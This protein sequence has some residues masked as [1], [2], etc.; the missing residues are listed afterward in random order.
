MPEKT[1]AH[2]EV[3]KVHRAFVRSERFQSEWFQ[4]LEKYYSLYRAETKRSYYNVV[5]RSQYVVPVIFKT[6]ETILPRLL[7]VTFSVSPPI[8]SRWR[9]APPEM[10]A[11]LK[12]RNLDYL[13]EFQKDN[14]N[15]FDIIEAWFKENLIYG[16]AYLKVGWKQR[17][18]K[19]KV[20]VLENGVLREKEIDDVVE[21]RAEVQ[22][23]DIFNLFFSP[24][25]KFPDPFDTAKYVIFRTRKRKSEV[26]AMRDAGQYND[27]DEDELMGDLENDPQRRKAA[28]ISRAASA[29]DDPED[30]MVTIYEYWEDD[31]LT[32]TANHRVLLRDEPNPFGMPGRPK[33][34]PFVA[35][36]D[37]LIPNELF[38]V[39]EAE[40]L[41]H[42]QVELSTL[43]RMRTDNNNLIIN[44]MWLYDK[45]AN[46]DLE[47]LELSRPGGAVGVEAM[48][49]PIANVLQPLAQADLNGASYK[50]FQDLDKDAQE[51]SGLLDYAVGSAPERRETATT[52]QLLQT[53]ANQRFDIKVRNNNEGVAKLG[54]MLHERWKQFL[55][56]PVA[57]RVPKWQGMGYIYQNITRD[58]LP[59]LDEVDL[60]V[61]GSPELLLKDARYQKM[62]QAYGAIMQNPAANPQAGLKLLVLTLKE[63]NLDGIEP[64]VQLLEQPNPMMGMPGMPM[65]GNGGA[66]NAPQ[67]PTAPPARQGVNESPLMVQGARPER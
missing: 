14:Y 67:P 19:R 13:F 65:P 29:E 57:I 58:D 39:G 63:M 20:P 43:R 32:V 28:S 52:V 44:R 40:P 6:V 9:S 21:D 3:T 45:N 55:T 62:M 11:E 18:Q 54:R 2:P 34:K 66:P 37:T 46:V 49:Q 33:K 4:R 41:E 50:E 53:A 42:T 15:L 22:P 30:P 17:I 60:S 5:T 25:A 26:I 59:E 56:R 31:W 8:Q 24:E 23:V 36:Y 51:I 12:L 35:I 61:P 38:Q 47:S 1:E 27:F 16:Q 64:I 10:G 7:A 48:G